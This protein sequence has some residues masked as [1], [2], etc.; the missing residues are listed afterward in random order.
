LVNPLVEYDVPKEK[1]E[2]WRRVLLNDEDGKR[3]LFYLLDETGFF[4]MGNTQ[5]AQVLR[6]FGT[7]ILEILGIAD[8]RGMF[9][10]VKLMA[11]AKPFLEPEKGE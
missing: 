3:V 11:Q 1:R 9:D 5:E 2:V 6:N 7:R 8:P 4:E 10:L